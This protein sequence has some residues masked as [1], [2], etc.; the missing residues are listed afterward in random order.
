MKGT[1]I[2]IIAVLF[3][4]AIVI[5]V[6]SGVFTEKISDCRIT[7]LQYDKQH[8]LTDDKSFD[9]DVTISNFG[10]SN[11]QVS[12]IWTSDFAKSLNPFENTAMVYPSDN[13]IQ[14]K[15]MKTFTLQ[16]FVLP[17]DSLKAQNGGNAERNFKVY[18][19]LSNLQKCAGNSRCSQISDNGYTIITK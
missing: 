9:I 12:Y 6:L 2:I 1:T 14:P 17:T 11:C 15:Q 10:N 4:I 13:I 3:V 16:G 5:L 19:S 18:V 7:G 8:I